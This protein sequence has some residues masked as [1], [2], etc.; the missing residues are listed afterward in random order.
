MIPN[1]FDL[2]GNDLYVGLGLEQIVFA[3]A[4]KPAAVSHDFS[5]NSLVE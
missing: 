4:A 2:L 5:E 3:L 1:L